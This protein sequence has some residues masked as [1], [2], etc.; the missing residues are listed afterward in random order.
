MRDLKTCCSTQRIG[1]IATEV[2][3][4]VHI[5]ELDAESMEPLNPY[6]EEMTGLIRRQRSIF[7]LKK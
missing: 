5:A 4:S 2:L 3:E 7:A 1:F 6:L